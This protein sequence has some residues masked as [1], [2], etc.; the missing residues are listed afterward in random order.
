MR[1]RWSCQRDYLRASASNCVVEISESQRYAVGL[2]TS[3]GTPGIRTDKTYDVET[4]GA[5]RRN[6]NPTAKLGADNQRW[7]F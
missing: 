3:P 1:V 5:Q 6:V 4:R 7:R 2:G